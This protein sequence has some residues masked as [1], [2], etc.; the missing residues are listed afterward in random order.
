MVLGQGDSGSIGTYTLGEETGYGLVCYAESPAVVEKYRRIYDHMV[1]SFELASDVVTGQDNCQNLLSGA[2]IPYQDLQIF[3]D[4]EYTTVTTTSRDFWDNSKLPK[5]VV[6]LEKKKYECMPMP[7]EFD[8]QDQEGDMLVQSEVKTVEWS[9][10]L[11]Y[12]DY[13]YLSSVDN[14]AMKEMVSSGYE[15]NEIE[16]IDEIGDKSAVWL[17]GK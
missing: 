12:I 7:I 6:E 8:S 5:Q 10:G 16:C 17:C 13:E 14:V 15:C 3:T 1:E 9:C 2:V 4:S 11:E